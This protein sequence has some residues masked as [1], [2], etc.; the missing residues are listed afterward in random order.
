MVESKKWK[1]FL[2]KSGLPLEYEIKKILEEKGALWSDERSYLKADENKIINEFSI[3]IDAS[4]INKDYFFKLFIEC[5]YRDES[6]NWFFLPESY[7]WI[8]EL[9]EWCFLHPCDHFN[10]NNKF[11]FNGV[12]P[13]L[14]KACWK[15]IEINSEGANPKTIT[16]AI[17]QLSYWLAEDIVSNFYHQL[18]YL[19]GT[20]REVIFCNIPIII[21]TAN[22]YRIKSDIGIEEIKNTENILDISTEEDCLVIKN[23]I[24]EDLKGHNNKIFKDFINKY[25]RDKLNLRLKSFNE[26]IDFVCEVIAEHYCPQW[27]LVIHYSK[28][29]KI[30]DKLFNLLDDISEQSPVLLNRI[31][32]KEQEYEK[33]TNELKNKWI[34]L[35]NL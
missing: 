15:G 18:D 26:D 33:I 34:N 27:I 13:P 11:I 4:Y 5:R 6:T 28:N 7:D 24:W 25:G 21:T 8:D 35:D 29:S 16:Q 3:D 2:L 30:F 14:W 10:E 22:L 32:E 23:K 1:N 20:N 31:K 17:N 12:I 9:D 19:L